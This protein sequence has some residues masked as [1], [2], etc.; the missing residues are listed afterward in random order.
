M[1]C[2]YVDFWCM[3]TVSNSRICDYGI[4]WEPD[5]YELSLNLRAIPSYLAAVMRNGAHMPS[6]GRAWQ[7]ND[8]IRPQKA[9]DDQAKLRAV[10]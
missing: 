3:D 8:S 4:K 10:R 7:L 5:L 1:Q 6:Q 2:T 9:S